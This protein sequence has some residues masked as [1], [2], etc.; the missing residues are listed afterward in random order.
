MKQLEQARA[1]FWSS[2]RQFAFRLRASRAVRAF[3]AFRQNIVNKHL[4]QADQENEQ[5]RLEMTSMKEA[6]FVNS[7][8][9]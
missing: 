7:Q 9:R 3:R 4:A 5:S 6:S 8:M 2:A 1:D